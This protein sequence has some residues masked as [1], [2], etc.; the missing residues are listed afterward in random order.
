MGQLP[1]TIVIQNA[2]NQKSIIHHTFEN[3]LD[4]VFEKKILLLNEKHEAC[5][6]MYDHVWQ[7]IEYS[8]FISMELQDK[9]FQN[10]CLVCFQM[11]DQ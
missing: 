9:V 11:Y 4:N 6:C 3:I 1:E 5:L 10:R 2:P 7:T 8:R